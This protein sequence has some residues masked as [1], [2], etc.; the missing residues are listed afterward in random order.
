MYGPLK[1]H[2]STYI[3]TN[4]C[5]L[6]SGGTRFELDRDTEKPEKIFRVFPSGP[7]QNAGI[8]PQIRPRHIFSPYT[9]V[10]NSLFLNRHRR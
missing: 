7:K 4:N 9:V 3:T 8:V 1:G 10:S 6:N 5:D 2:W